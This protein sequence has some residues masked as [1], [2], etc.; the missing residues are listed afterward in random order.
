MN[1]HFFTNKIYQGRLTILSLLLVHLFILQNVNAQI[2]NAPCNSNSPWV[3]STYTNLTAQINDNVG[4]VIPLCIGGVTNIGNLIDDNLSNFTTINITGVGCNATIGVTDGTAADTYSAG[5]WAGFRIGTSGL[6]GVSVS[7]TVT[8][9][10]FNN[11]SPVESQLVV[12]NLLGLDSDLIFADG[13]ANVGFVTTSPFDE[14]RITFQTLVGVLW[15]AQ[16]YHAVITKYC[17]GPNPACNTMTALTQTEY[18]AFVSDAGTT[19]VTLGSVTNTQN[20]VDGNLNNFGSITLPLGILSSGF[21]SVK[22]QLTDYVAGTFAGFEVSNSNILG[23]DLLQ[24]T[25]ITT[26]LNGAIRET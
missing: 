22:D 4:S 15:S 9:Q 24:N 2:A 6:L 26:Y 12:S 19:G 7:S 21:I 17:V 8:V 16:I 13:T 25:T 20:V 3:D 10:T 23:V 11:G 14:V 5:T 1:S 18:P